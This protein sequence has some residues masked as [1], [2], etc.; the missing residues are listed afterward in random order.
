MFVKVCVCISYLKDNMI[1][2]S[3]S[4]IQTAIIRQIAFPYP[5]NSNGN[6]SKSPPKV[7]CTRNARGT[8]YLNPSAS[9]VSGETA[10]LLFPSFQMCN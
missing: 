9:L 5:D 4:L 8:R 1:S 6:A 7:G 2:V 10:R 3:N